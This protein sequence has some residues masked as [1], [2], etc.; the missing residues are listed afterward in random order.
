ML[1]SRVEGEILK[2][3][4]ENN[5]MYGTAPSNAIYTMF[6]VII[7][8]GVPHFPTSNKYIDNQVLI[9]I[10]LGLL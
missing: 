1:A 10:A 8:H 2:L 7:S 9:I 5:H 6:L 3:C 4:Y